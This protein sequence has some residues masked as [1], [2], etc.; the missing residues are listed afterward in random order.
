MQQRKFQE[1]LKRDL[2]PK[3]KKAES[4]VKYQAGFAPPKAPATPAAPA[5]K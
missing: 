3:V 1:L 2:E 4:E 5:A